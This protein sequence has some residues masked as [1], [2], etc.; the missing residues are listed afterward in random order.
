MRPDLLCLSL[1]L[2]G[3][4]TLLSWWFLPTQMMRFIPPASP[5]RL[6]GPW[7]VSGACGGRAPPAREVASRTPR[8]TFID[9][10]SKS[11]FPGPKGH[12]RP[13]EPPGAQV[14]PS[15]PPK[16]RA[17]DDKSYVVTRRAA[18]VSPE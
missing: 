15:G 5:R 2:D 16:G 11:L 7:D 12:P 9:N 14:A 4:P 17:G 10:S 6:R 1:L 3:G 8:F 18:P 13:G